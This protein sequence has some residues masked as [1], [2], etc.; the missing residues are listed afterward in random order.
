MCHLT[1]KLLPPQS[2]L[3]FYPSFWPVFSL[4]RGLL[5]SLY[6]ISSLPASYENLSLLS[7][8]PI[9]DTS[10]GEMEG[11]RHQSSAR[12]EHTLNHWSS[13]SN[14]RTWQEKT[15]TSSW[16]SWESRRA[17]KKGGR[18]TEKAETLT[19]FCDYVNIS[20]LYFFH[21]FSVC[22]DRNNPSIGSQQVGF[23]CV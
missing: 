17:L 16:H 9:A 18:S 4:S 22:N 21:T 7:S 19:H 13:S 6:P 2:F 11:R 12:S 15:C 5:S 20:G 23:L 3:L 1:F 10:E 8:H 14:C